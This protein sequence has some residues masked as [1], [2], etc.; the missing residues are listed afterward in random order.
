MNDKALRNL[1]KSCRQK[2]IKAQKEL[3]YA[4]VDRVYYVVKRYVSDDYFVNNIVQDVFLKVF[5][6]IDKYDEEKGMFSTW[7]NTISVRESISYVRK[8]KFDLILD[9][10][11]VSSQN[12]KG[13]V[14]AKLNADDIL[15]VLSSINDK[16]R[17]VFNLYE[18][19]GFSHKEIGE[20]LGITESSSRTYLTRAK[21]IL[22]DKIIKLGI[23]QSYSYGS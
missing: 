8:K 21:N 6:N 20:L 11:P 17:I 19:D 23:I 13:D 15:K 16:Y 2:E 10:N 5:I 1:I 9:L 22:K 12:I 4:F 14:L 7:I 18:I 3:Y